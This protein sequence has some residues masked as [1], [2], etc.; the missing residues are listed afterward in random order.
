MDKEFLAFLGLAITISLILVAAEFVGVLSSVK[1]L[2]VKDT[3]LEREN[4]S[5]SMLYL[6]YPGIMHVHSRYSDGSGDFPEIIE[7][8]RKAGACY[9]ITA[10]HN[11]LKPL[12]EGWEGWHGDTLVL[13][14][15]EISTASGHYLALNIGKESWQEDKYPQTVIDK[16]EE[17]G[18][19]GFIAHPYSLKRP[20]THWDVEGY[21]GLE[22]INLESMMWK[23]FKR[24]LGLLFLLKDLLKFRLINLEIM[25]SFI[26]IRPEVELKK[27]DELTQRRKIVGIGSVDAHAALKIDAKVYSFPSYEKS[28]R[29]VYTHILLPEKLT[30]EYLE[31][32]KQIYQ[33]LRQGNAYIAFDI[34]SSAEGFLFWAQ[35]EAGKALMGDSL[36]LLDGTRLI[37]SLPRNGIIG[38]YRNGK[39]IEKVIGQQL[40][41]RATQS[42][43]YRI[44][45]EYYQ[46]RLP[47]GFFYGV[48]PWIYSNPIYVT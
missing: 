21:V 18:G 2:R 25:N 15:N 5:S 43:V 23:S 32:K 38:L 13:V 37:A 48:K 1:R 7:A 12:E 6:D 8:A 16:V 17:Q 22:V 40:V 26:N 24:H 33:A 41:Y 20:W 3:S 28:L 27:W 29:T 36:T 19:L 11:T 30:G 14:A 4:I 10:D 39:L 31:D 45:V 46:G 9:L 42:G 44:E 34:L 35:N 47:F